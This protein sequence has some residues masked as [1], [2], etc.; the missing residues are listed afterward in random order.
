MN[1]LRRCHLLLLV[2]LLLLPLLRPCA[3]GHRRCCYT[4]ELLFR[5]V[6]V[7][8]VP[9]LVH[10]NHHVTVQE[11]D[12]PTLGYLSFSEPPFAT[13]AG[14]VQRW[15]LH[16]ALLAGRYL[17]GWTLITYFLRTPNWVPARTFQHLNNLCVI[18]YIYSEGTSYFRP[19]LA[20]LSRF[21]LRS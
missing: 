7:D 2:L 15:W 19:F 1:L 16:L 10:L 20:L 13:F 8:H 21:S 5:C 12:E 4:A 14:F 3:Y 18:S 9:F 11:V 17:A 6:L